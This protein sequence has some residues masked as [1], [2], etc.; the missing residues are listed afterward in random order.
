MADTVQGAVVDR[1]SGD[2]TMSTLLAQHGD[3]AAGFPDIHVP[4][5]V[6][7]PFFCVIV[8]SAASDGSKTTIGYDWRLLI[9]CFAGLTQQAELDAVTARVRLLMHHN[10]LDVGDMEG[11]LAV[12][13]MPVPVAVANAL[14]QEVPVRLRAMG[15]AEPEGAPILTEEGEAMLTEDDE[16]MLMEV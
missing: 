16:P 11:W 14:C 3:T 6:G 5:D 1:L 9:R 10:P 4:A 7:Y 13:E 15:P 2:E 12:A 8:R